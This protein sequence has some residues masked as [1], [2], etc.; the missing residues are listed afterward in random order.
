[1][2]K[3]PP[4]APAPSTRFW[5]TYQ[6]AFLTILAFALVAVTAGVVFDVLEAPPDG[7]TS[8][9]VSENSEEST[10]RVRA[11]GTRILGAL[12]PELDEASGIAVNTE[13]GTVWAHNDD[14]GTATL[15][16]I[17]MEGR[18]L[19]AYDVPGVRVTD[20]EDVDRA[21]CPGT[22]RARSCVYLA[23]TGDNDRIR[24]ASQIIV[25]VEP[26]AADA[27]VEVVGST[28]FTYEDGRGR[29]VE[30]LT[31][32]GERLLLVSKGQEGAAQVFELGLEALA[33]VDAA[34][35][36]EPAGSP[37]IARH[38]GTLSIDVSDDTNRPTG[39]AVSPDGASLA[40]RTARTVYRFSL[41]DLEAAPIACPIGVD[42]PQGEAIDFL[43]D[44]RVLLTGEKGS[45]AEPAPFVEIE[46]PG[47][48]DRRADSI[49]AAPEPET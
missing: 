19:G 28:I 39:A 43:D 13:S 2:S 7:E 37:A 9:P 47:S 14:P 12:P 3:S 1:M 31:V 17:D 18:L 22:D 29:D 5:S 38:I 25:L 41:E 21:P 32:S 20:L 49:P 24:T 4:A 44:R 33:P 26:S 10:D 30:S 8:P 23:D 45:G 6:L 46:C 36:V 27:E 48:A 11:S 40:V 42:E 34:S 15:F 16:A 35:S